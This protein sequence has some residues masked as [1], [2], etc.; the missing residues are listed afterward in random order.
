MVFTS[1]LLVARCFVTIMKS[2]TNNVTVDFICQGMDHAVG[3]SV[4]TPCVFYAADGVGRQ[5]HGSFK[6]WVLNHLY[7]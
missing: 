2:V 6:F 3:V 1:C 4:I 7:K 5:V